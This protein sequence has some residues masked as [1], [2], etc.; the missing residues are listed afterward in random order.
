MCLLRCLPRSWWLEV[1][2][3]EGLGAIHRRVH[4]T[5]T[6]W[7]RRRGH[8]RQ[9]RLEISIPP[10]IYYT[11]M[12]RHMHTSIGYSAHARNE[13]PYWHQI[14]T[15]HHDTGSTSTNL[16]CSRCLF[17]VMVIPFPL[18][19]AV[20]KLLPQDIRCSYKNQL[21]PMIQYRG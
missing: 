18:Q 7:L 12:F 11:A 17:Q 3:T 20:G 6:S 15:S 9:N 4:F 14:Q 10:A 5:T 1:T 2:L 13:F 8:E 21:C 16:M 19:W